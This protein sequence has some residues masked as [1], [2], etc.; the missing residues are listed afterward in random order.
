MLLKMACKREKSSRAWK[1]FVIEEEDGRK[2]AVCKQCGLKLAYS[3]GT[4]NLLTHID[5]KHPELS[6]K[7]QSSGTQLT[8][9]TGRKCSAHRSEEITKAIAEFVAADLRPIA[10]ID[11]KGFKKLMNL[12]EPD[13]KVPSRPHITSTCRKMY[14]NLKE[15]LL[16]DLK[17]KYVSLTTDSWTSRMTDSYTTLTVHW[18]NEDWELQSKVL[19]TKEMS[20]RHT[21]EN[22]ATCLKQACVHW[23]IPEEFIV[24]LVHDNASNMTT[25]AR[26]LGWESLPCVAH[27]L[28]LAVNKGLNISQISRQSAVCR[29]LVGHFK[30]SSLAM[31]ALKEKQEQLNLEKHHLIQD[32]STR[33]NSTYFM[34][35]RLLEQRWGIYAV[36]HDEKVSEAKYRCLNPT[37]TQWAL[38][39]DMAKV[40]KPLQI[41][42]TALC[43]SEIVSV[44][45]VY[46][47][48][49]SLITK[50]L[51]RSE[52]DSA[53]LAEFK[54][55]VTEELRQR[56][57]IDDI[58]IA[59][60]VPILAAVLD[61]R[62]LHLSFLSVRQR[63]IATAVIREK[64]KQI[65]Q[66]IAA[67]ETREEE[68][69]EKDEPPLKK[70][71]QETA[72]SFLMGDQ[73]VEN[74]DC[75]GEEEVDRY[76]AQKAI[77]T[78][79]NIN[80]L[81]YWR[82]NCECYP[83]LASLAKCLLCVPATSVPAERVFSIAGLT[84]THQRCSL[85]PDNADMLIFL[86]KNLP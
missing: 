80:I 38:L 43:E 19:F 36:L 59:D 16:G 41:A 40:L 6:E 15:Q 23:E 18:I 68:S 39:G 62:H 82:Q 78:N 32:V 69:E 49:H 54:L 35:E 50:H 8:L 74:H 12:L 85:S 37:E 13:Y 81:D 84:I 61:P 29:K 30:H 48:I 20:E 28:Q 65:F 71:K 3:G 63:S 47:I 72:L 73:E 17:Y 44:S 79:S 2:K 26:E 53:V 52:D 14:N 42:T 22:I 25:A 31:T 4:G 66:K 10:L 75:N 56:F 51:F 67:A 76:L 21:G 86:Q 34:F 83:S 27:T 9:A 33:W 7:P 1:T 57:K 55:T 5:V 11:G 70:N 45:L 60:K 77:T 64:S 46:P 58:G 24:A